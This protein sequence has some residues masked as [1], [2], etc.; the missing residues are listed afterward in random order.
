[1]ATTQRALLLVCLNVLSFNSPCAHALRVQRSGT[2][3]PAS[4]AQQESMQTLQ[5]VMARVEPEITGLPMVV[6][7]TEKLPLIAKH[8]PHIG[9]S[10]EY[11]HS[12]PGGRWFK[13]TIEL[14]PRIIGATGDIRISDIG[15]V[16]DFMLLNEEILLQHWEQQELLIH[17]TCWSASRSWNDV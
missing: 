10:Q 8:G 13:M 17:L 3:Q 1:M 11:G 6:F 14:N 15:R 16:R 9:V 7:L 4:N 5:S 2:S 12:L